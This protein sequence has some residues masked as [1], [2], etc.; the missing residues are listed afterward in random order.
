MRS[1]SCEIGVSAGRGRESV[2]GRFN[3]GKDVKRTL[4]VG[5]AML[6][7]GSWR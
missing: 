6:D 7:R 1:W 3:P 2:Q 4:T 5:K